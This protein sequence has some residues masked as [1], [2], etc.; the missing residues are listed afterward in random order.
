MMILIRGVDSATG[1]IMRIVP[2]I[3]ILHTVYGIYHLGRKPSGRTP[4]S[5][6]SYMLFAAF[7]DISIVPFYAFSALVAKTRETTWKTV[8]SNQDLVPIFSTVVFYLAAVGGGLYL[9]SL[10]VSIY[11]AV[12]FR[13]ITKLRTLILADFLIRK[14][15][16]SWSASHSTRGILLQ[17]QK[18]LIYAYTDSNIAPDMNP[19]EDHL[20]S[21]HKRNKSS[22][23]T[24]TT[25]SEKRTSSPWESKSSS[26]APYE[27]LSRPPM[28][29]FFHTRSGSTESFSTHKSTRPPTG[30]SRLDLPSRQYQIT[31]TSPRS[32]VVDLKRNSY[33]GGPPTSPKRAPYAEEPLSDSASQR[34][35]RPGGNMAEAWFTA[36]SISNKRGR[37]AS[38]KKGYQPLYQR[39][40]SSQDLS[41]GHPNPLEANPPTPRH[42]HNHRPRRDSALS[43]ISSNR[44]TS[45]DIADVSSRVREAAPVQQE[46]KAKRYGELKP[47]T[48][49]IMI[50]GNNRQVSSGTDFSSKGGFRV[51]DVSGKIAEEGRGGDGNGWGTRFRKISGL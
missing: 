38:P 51:R 42:S 33:H 44:R 18:Y 20:T 30:D 4:A 2:G 14:Y 36:D 32:S 34:P 6:A 43:E 9:T 21:R 24:T 17:P 48:P 29:P 10:G 11:L 45:G 50:G 23:S 13:K 15:F 28:I 26:G 35:S 1:W 3:A 8:I 12:T 16:P 41:L 31:S 7:F 47:G 19:L 46:F 25:M 27:D 40:D 22:L 5:S 39:R 37:A 49:P